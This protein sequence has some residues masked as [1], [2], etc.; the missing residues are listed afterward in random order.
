M[1][2]GFATPERS[3][4][5]TLVSFHLVNADSGSLSPP[6]AVQQYD[7]VGLSPISLVKIQI[8]LPDRLARL[9]EDSFSGNMPQ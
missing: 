8:Y 9:P 6:P 7:A 5:D 3:N 2:T 1:E 4:A